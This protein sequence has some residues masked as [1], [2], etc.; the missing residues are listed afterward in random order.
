MLI[1]DIGEMMLSRVMETVFLTVFFDQYLLP[2][3]Y[4]C[5]QHRT[6]QLLTEGASLPVN[7]T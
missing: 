1:S 4:L 6:L 7:S 2:P 3:P 5:G